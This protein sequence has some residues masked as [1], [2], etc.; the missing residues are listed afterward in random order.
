MN[1]YLIAHIEHTGKWSEHV[2]WWKPDSRGYTLC[3]DKAGTYSEDEARDICS[4]GSCIAVAFSVANQV[5]RS[6]PYYR[7]ADGNLAKLYD[8]DKHR[9]VPNLLNVWKHLLA[10]RLHGCA[11]PVKPTPIGARAR[12]IYIDAI[13]A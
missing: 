2:V 9:V 8:G 6:T 11:H 12:A 13:A 1:G 10:G 7:Q 3:I 5:S 4:N